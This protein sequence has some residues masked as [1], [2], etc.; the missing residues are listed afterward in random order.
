MELPAEAIRT[1]EVLHWRGVHL[2]HYPMSSCSQKVRIL[3]DEKHLDWVSHPV[4][5]TKGEQR[6]DW[7]LG[8]NPAGVVPVL[9][10][11]GHVWNESNDILA[12]LDDAFPS[13]APYLP[14]SD[15]ERRLAAELLQLEEGLHAHLRVVTFSFVMPG[16]LMNH[17]FEPAEVEDAVRR[18][19]EVLAELD[20]RLGDST[21][22]CGDR[23]MLP[24]IAWFITLHRLVLAGYPL[25]RRPHLARYHQALLSRPAFRREANAGA[26]LPRVIGH[27]YRS[28]NRL[29]GATLG[30]RLLG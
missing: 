30:D 26:L 29:R 3:L 22:L 15:S 21:C 9:V 1:K 2:L 19:D 25:D 18:F 8:I 10:H 5:L 13:K 7:Y 11:D 17:V 12:Y 20:A 28:L 27:L 24:D 4:D 6:S 16:A 23:V 14:A